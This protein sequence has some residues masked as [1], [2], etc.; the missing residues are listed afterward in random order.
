MQSEQQSRQSPVLP[1][2]FFRHSHSARTRLDS[3]TIPTAKPVDRK[4]CAGAAL[5]SP[6]Q[7][8]C[9]NLETTHPP[10]HDPWPGCWTLHFRRSFCHS[11]IASPS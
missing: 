9:G 4:P 10:L 2:F 6:Q 8:R 3:F 1:R 7:S 11:A 5:D